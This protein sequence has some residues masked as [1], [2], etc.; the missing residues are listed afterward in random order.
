MTHYLDATGLHTDS[1]A[2]VR[3]ELVDSLHAAI[4]PVLDLSEE[5]PD[6]NLISLL[7]NRERAVVEL[8][9]EVYAGQYPSTA[10]G[11]QLDLSAAMTGCYRLDPTKSLLLITEADVK[12]DAFKTLP[13][14]SVAHVTG[15]PSARFVTIGD[16]TNA[17]GV[18]AWVPCAFEAEETGPIQCLTGALTTIAEPV[19]GWLEVINTADAAPGSDEEEDAPYRIRRLTELYQGGAA[20]AGAVRADLASLTDMVWA[21]VLEND[22]DWT[23]GDG[24]PA[25]SIAPVVYDG[26]PAGGPHIVSDVDI[27][28]AILGGINSGKAGGNRSWGSTV[29]GV[30]DSQGRNHV[31]GFTRAEELR[32]YILVDLS[33]VGCYDEDLYPAGA[34][35]KA[36]IR[37]ALVTWALSDLGRGDDVVY[38]R[39]GAVILGVDGI[40]DITALTCGYAP[41]PGGI[42]NLPVGE[43]QIATVDSGDVGVTV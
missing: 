43:Y 17:L 36:A 14:G 6:G 42:V 30:E 29:V 13:A 18:A 33:G 5:S 27:A 11:F 38:L 2:V 39:L 22:G 8:A 12:L 34:G 24:I 7:A 4:S 20:T 23:D 10:V 9:E 26:A 28:A 35:L 25:H 16:V 31:I 37:Q 21:S 15:D 3:Q 40:Y 19:L 1:Y 41:A 32:V